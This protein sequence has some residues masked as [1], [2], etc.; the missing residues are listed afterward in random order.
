MDGD[1]FQMKKALKGGIMVLTGGWE[2]TGGGWRRIYSI[3]LWFGK[4]AGQQLNGASLQSLSNML[5]LTLQSPNLEVTKQGFIAFT[6][7]TQCLC[8][9]II[10]DGDQVILQQCVQN[11]HSAVRQSIRTLHVCV[12]CEL[13]P[14]TVSCRKPVLDKNIC[15]FML[16]YVWIENQIFHRCIWHH[17]TS[18]ADICSHTHVHNLY[19]LCALSQ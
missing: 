18:C 10:R 17:E 6:F 1:E 2:R 15:T 14:L 5:G 4:T 19:I 12:F 3:T 13:K 9:I 7:Q 11:L 16:I 8:N